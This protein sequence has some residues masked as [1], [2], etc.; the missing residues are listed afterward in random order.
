MLT[1]RIEYLF[2]VGFYLYYTFDVF[3]VVVV[4][5]GVA[6]TR[7]CAT[8]SNDHTISHNVTLCMVHTI[9]RFRSKTSCA[10]STALLILSPR[11]S[12]IDE[13]VN[14]FDFSQFPFYNAHTYTINNDMQ[15]HA[16]W[17]DNIV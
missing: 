14:W 6:G 12:P 9:N 4:G 2:C 8:C 17:I 7:T 10:M 15:N 11:P 16:S 5:A 13:F 3:F 1:V